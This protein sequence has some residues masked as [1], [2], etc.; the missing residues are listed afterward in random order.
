MA[1]PLDWGQSR[2]ASTRRHGIITSRSTVSLA[3]RR[4][5]RG[6]RSGSAS[7][8]IVP[9]PLTTC[10]HAPGPL[11]HG[12]V[13]VPAGA[14]ARGAWATRPSKQRGGSP[15]SS[16]PALPWG[17]FAFLDRLPPGERLVGRQ[18]GAAARNARTHA[19]QGLLFREHPCREAQAAARERSLR[20]LCGLRA[21]G[22]SGWPRPAWW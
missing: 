19:R 16:R 1:A 6:R 21:F 9:Q 2:Q 17:L 10:I 3:G 8:R 5:R 13:S 15:I 18:A 11:A 7:R 4:G 14:E 20:G 22:A 12:R